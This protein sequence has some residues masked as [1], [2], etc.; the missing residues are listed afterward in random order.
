MGG[1]TSPFQQQSL[2]VVLKRE[3]KRM[4]KSWRN[5]LGALLQLKE[6]IFMF[7]I[8]AVNE[9]PGTWLGSMNS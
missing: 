1:L 6:P 4:T 2:P 7:P 8:W 3:K 5:R 9:H